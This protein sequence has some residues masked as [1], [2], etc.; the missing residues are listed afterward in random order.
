[1]V[2]LIAP[3]SAIHVGMAIPAGVSRIV[4]SG[5]MPNGEIWSTGFWVQG[6][7]PDSAATANALA[8]LAFDE[9]SANDT[10]G[11]MRLVF[12]NLA[13]AQTIW[14]EVKAYCYPSG[15][16]SA[17]FIGS[18]T[19]PSPLVGSGDGT[20]PNQCALVLSLRSG[21]AGRSKRGRMYLPATGATLLS[22]GQMDQSVLASITNGWALG[23]SDWNAASDGK[24]VVVSQHL[25]SAVQVSS[26]I[27][28]SR[29][30]IQRSRANSEVIKRSSVGAVTL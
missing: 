29:I 6:A 2:S 1:M 22:D 7:T 3:H 4:F 20:L 14:N 28:D 21:F 19:I 13:N 11:A 15:G 10:S 26:V 12:N 24:I 5:I 8:E 16:P 30:D 17:Q 27:C 18:Y 23:F 25:D 9:F